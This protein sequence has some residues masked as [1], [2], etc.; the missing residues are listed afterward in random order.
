MWRKQRENVQISENFS[1][2]A[3]ENNQVHHEKCHSVCELGGC[4]NLIN[5]EIKNSL[6]FSKPTAKTNSKSQL[7]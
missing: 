5:K 2:F 3:Q 1:E 6:E 4:I 7:N